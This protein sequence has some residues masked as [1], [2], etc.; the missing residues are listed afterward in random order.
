MLI[1]AMAA[2]GA[3]LTSASPPLQHLTFNY[4][5]AVWELGSDP[6]ITPHIMIRMRSSSIVLSLAEKRP[7]PQGANTAGLL[8]HIVASIRSAGY[9]I[10][11]TNALDG[12]IKPAGWSCR[13]FG[14]SRSSDHTHQLSMECVR[15][16]RD[17]SA[18]LTL[19]V[20]DAAGSGAFGVL[21]GVL[22]SLRTSGR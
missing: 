10:A 3:T 6:D 19:I 2:T 20:P 15:L 13:S 16:E 5:A 11:A 8:D 12:V 4:D 22:A 9:E 18:R 17:Y 7:A 21:N 1:P 14:A